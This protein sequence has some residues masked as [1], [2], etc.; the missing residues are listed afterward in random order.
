MTTIEFA[1]RR[2]SRKRFPLPTEAQVRTLERRIK[3]A[4]PDD[5]RQFLLEYNGGYFTEPA[6]MP[7]SEGCPQ[8]ALAFL[9]GIGASHPEAE[10][11]EP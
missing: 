7:V 6:I 4:F 11:G 2:F 9:S 10:L 8:D 1:Y 3:V 5:Y